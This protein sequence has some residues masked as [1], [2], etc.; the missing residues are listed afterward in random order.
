V[1]A[2]LNARRV[3]GWRSNQGD[4]TDTTVTASRTRL[5]IL[6]SR[7]HIST[8]RTAKAKDRQ[9][10]A[11]R[12]VTLQWSHYKGVKGNDYRVVNETRRLHSFRICRAQP[13]SDSLLG[14]WTQT[15]LMG[16]FKQ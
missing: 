8:H 14:N 11:V 1:I 6:M 5:T 10:D 15:G 9:L 3:V 7:P 16:V 4:T 12:V 13:L 2:R